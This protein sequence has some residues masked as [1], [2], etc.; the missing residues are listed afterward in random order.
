M[1]REFIYRLHCGDCSFGELC[2]PKEMLA[3]LRMLGMMRRAEE[4][5]AEIVAELFVTAA[6]RLSCPECGR[7]GLAATPAE[8][9]DGDWGQARACKRCGE[10]IPAERVELFPDVEHCAT[11]Q[12]KSDVGDH[13]DEREFCPHCGGVMQMQQS[14]GSGLARY[15]MVC[16]GC[17]R[18]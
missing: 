12:G 4:P 11:C 15:A 17:G 13:Q 14:R 8:E 3:R 2:D 7:Q 6:Q 9:D 1:S 10:P 18:R 5:K 16:S